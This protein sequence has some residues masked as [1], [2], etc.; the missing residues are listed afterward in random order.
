MIKQHRIVNDLLKDDIK[1]MH[2]LQV[3]PLVALLSPAAGSRVVAR[4][5]DAAGRTHVV[6]CVVRIQI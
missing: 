4:S 6:V 5:R 2:G 1:G 3:R